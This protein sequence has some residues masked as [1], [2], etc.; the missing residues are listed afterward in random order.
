MHSKF[1]Y[2]NSIPFFFHF[3]VFQLILFNFQ[4]YFN[5]SRK[6]FWQYFRIHFGS[7]S[8]IFKLDKTRCSAQFLFN[9]CFNSE[10]SLIYILV[11]RLRILI[12]ISNVQGQY[13]NVF[14]RPTVDFIV[15]SCN[16][17]S[18]TPTPPS[19]LRLFLFCL[20]VQKMQTLT[21]EDVWWKL[22][23]QA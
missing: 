15:D 18:P 17:H 6:P 7:F 20:P 2:F 9:F 10:S 16:C 13:L 5:S 11:E 4:L 14:Q 22:I 8:T 21:A 3:F 1:V 12:S 19:I 23:K